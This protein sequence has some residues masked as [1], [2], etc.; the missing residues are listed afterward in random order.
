MTDGR[1]ARVDAA[2]AEYVQAAEAGAAPERAAWL[3]KYSDLRAELEEFLAD[4]SAFRAAAQPVDQLTLP[5]RAVPSG[6]H[7]V[8]RYFGDYELVGEIARSGMGVV[9]RARRTDDT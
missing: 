3:A 2:I 8:V 7:P 4:R 9:Y 1:E 6:D 5:L